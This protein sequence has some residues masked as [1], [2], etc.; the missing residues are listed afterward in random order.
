MIIEDATPHNIAK[1][2]AIQISAYDASTR[3]IEKEKIEDFLLTGS[4]QSGLLSLDV[5]LI[6]NTIRCKKWRLERLKFSTNISE[7]EL[8]KIDSII[9]KLSAVVFGECHFD[10]DKWRY[11]KVTMFYEECFFENDWSVYVGGGSPELIE[12][13]DSLFEKCSFAKGVNLVGNNISGTI[14]NSY[15]SIFYECSAEHLDVFNVTIFPVLWSNMTPRHER[16]LSALTVMSSNLGSELNLTNENIEKVMVSKSEV[17]GLNASLIKSHSV[18]FSDVVFTQAC[19]V[20]SGCV[21]EI[22][23]VDCNFERNCDLSGVKCHSLLISRCQFSRFLDCSGLGVLH[24]ISFYALILGREGIFN[25]LSPG[26][27]AIENADRETWRIIKHAMR[28]AGN[29]LEAA[30]F[31]A[32]EMQA[33]RGELKELKAKKS[34]RLLLW[35]NFMISNHGQSYVRSMAWLVSSICITALVLAND[36]NRWLTLP[37]PWAEVLQPAAN[38]LNS[39]ALGFLPLS[40][41]LNDQ[42]KHL[43]FFLLLATLLISTFAW[44]FLSALRKHSRQ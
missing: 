33:Y 18:C 42:N 15:S 16:K 8:E 4:A 12:E 2:L 19:I 30:E 20:S 41:L 27:S 21:D 24:S 22:R 1:Q 38:F 13:G 37:D 14:I 31:H 26:K 32:M 43:A 39:L 11:P 7:E 23:L 40:G 25:E 6:N 29:Q 10:T 3:R 9:E 5:K 44:H 36:R 34:E 28:N 17:A 35:L